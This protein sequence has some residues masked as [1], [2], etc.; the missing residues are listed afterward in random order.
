MIWHFQK[1]LSR[2]LLI[3]SALSVLV[4]LALWLGGADFWRGFGIQAALWG[5]I[6]AVIALAGLRGVAARLEGAVYADENARKARSLRRVLWIN[7][8][9]D[10]LYI[11]AG[12]GLLLWGK[13]A[14]LHGMGWGIIVQ[15]AF[16]LIF[17]V[18]HA[19]G[20]PMEEIR[21]PGLEVFERPEHLPYHLEGE[22]GAPLALLAH[23]FPGTTGELR[24]LAELLHA[25]GWSA[26]GLLV[27]G[28]GRELPGLFQQRAALWVDWLAG[29]VELARDSG[30]PVILIGFSLG[31]A[32]S[33]AAAARCKPDRLVLLAP[34]WWQEPVWLRL[35]W[36][37]LEALFSPT[38]QP[39]RA[40]PSGFA[41]MMQEARRTNVDLSGAP[42]ES[43]EQLR[44]LRL[45]L[46]FVDQFRR[47]SRRVG[48]AAAGLNMPVLILHG[49]QDTV[50]QP[51]FSRRLAQ[52]ISEHARFELVPGDHHTF[53]TGGEAFEQAAERIVAFGAE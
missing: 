21:L 53:M 25:A 38:I 30:R 7:G 35:L 20:T 37:G 28:L 31:G 47:L 41:Q 44:H 36:S 46:V 6:D 15:G 9:L 2:R 43:M 12:V 50:A 40:L 49:E 23:G 14:L 39:F 17:D 27:P 3:W 1:I 18:L 29:E 19:L 34:F 5:G 33:A 22:P 26:R 11:L 8:G 52:M 16:L 13:S 4:G 51:R 32:I 24:P 45:P 10:V 42:A 48:Q